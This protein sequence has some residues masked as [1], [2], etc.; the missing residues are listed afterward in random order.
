MFSLI[1]KNLTIYL[2]LKMKINENF[3]IRENI[4]T[5]V[6]NTERVKFNNSYINGAR[7]FAIENSDFVGN[8]LFEKLYYDYNN[9]SEDFNFKEFLL[10]KQNIVYENFKFI[11]FKDI[12]TFEDGNLINRRF[13]VFFRHHCENDDL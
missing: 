10:N 7:N 6:L 13:E 4:K 5:F 9:K 2:I 11:G 3:E 12:E 1:M 8:L